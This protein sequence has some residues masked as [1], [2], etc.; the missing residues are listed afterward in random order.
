VVHQ[1]H[2]FAGGCFVNQL[3]CVIGS[4]GEWLLD[5][6]MLA[7]FQRRHGEFKM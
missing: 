1:Q 4:G 7:G 3:A 5:K 2:K 6:H